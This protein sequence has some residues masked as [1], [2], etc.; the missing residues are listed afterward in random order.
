MGKR[1]L[2]LTLGLCCGLLGA[3]IKPTGIPQ[4]TGGN[5]FRYDDAG[6]QVFRGYVCSN[7]PMGNKGGETEPSAQPEA[8]ASSNPDED[9]WSEIQ[10]YPVPV[11]D[12]LTIAW[13]DLADQLI[14]EVGMYEQ[15]TVHWKFQ[16]KNL[17][18]LNRQVQVDMTHYYMG[19]YVLTFQLKDGRTISRNIIKL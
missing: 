3:Q 18:N 12:I 6:N 7:C 15:N 9:L 10:V 11:R 16:Q 19:V 17:P 1:Q 2:L 8:T 4:P 5:V 14:D 13:T